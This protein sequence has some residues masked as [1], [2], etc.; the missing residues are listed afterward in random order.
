M[1]LS[2]VLLESVALFGPD[3]YV[4]LAASIHKLLPEL[5][6]KEVA[7]LIYSENRK[8]FRK[9]YGAALTKGHLS[10]LD[11]HHFE[12]PIVLS[13]AKL[14]DHLHTV[15]YNIDRPSRELREILRKTRTKL[16]EQV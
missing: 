6:I 5:P 7:S 11:P 10:V 15:E 12:K 4:D 1:K 13:T 16:N 3:F 9:K 2:E 8:A 14:K